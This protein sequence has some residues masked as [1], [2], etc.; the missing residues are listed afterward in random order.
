MPLTSWKQPFVMSQNWHWWLTKTELIHPVPCALPAFWSLPG[1]SVF[2]KLKSRIAENATFD[3]LKVWVVVGHL[4]VPQFPVGVG[5]AAEAGQ[6]LLLLLRRVKLRQAGQVKICNRCQRIKL[7]WVNSFKTITVTI[8][9]T[10]NNAP[11]SS[12]R[13]SSSGT[14]E[15]LLLLL[16]FGSEIWGQQGEL[17]LVSS[18]SVSSQW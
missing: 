9:V 1:G 11:R 7:K 5:V 18:A 16:W 15:V 4:F 12:L 3:F 8:T 6:Q 2:F 17:G 10:L 13:S 14:V